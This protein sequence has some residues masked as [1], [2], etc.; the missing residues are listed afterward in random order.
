M[1]ALKMP[2]FFFQALKL[3]H[4]LLL[5]ILAGGESVFFDTKGCLDI[6]KV[7]L[8]LNQFEFNSA[9]LTSQLIEVRGGMALVLGNI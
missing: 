6:L 8:S 3:V 7:R 1:L 2:L 5:I 9:L 4:Q